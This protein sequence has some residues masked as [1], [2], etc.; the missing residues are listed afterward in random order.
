MLR[1]AL[2]LALALAG[3]AC[4]APSPAPATKPEAAPSAEPAPPAAPPAP[5]PATPAKARDPLCDAAA[6]PLEALRAHKSDAPVAY[7]GSPLQQWVA[8]SD[9]ATGR[10]DDAAISAVLVDT[11]PAGFAFVRARIEGSIAQWMR[12]RLKHAADDKEGRDAAW[13]AARCAWKVA[14]EPLAVELADAAPNLV[15]EIDAAFAAGEAALASGDPTAIDKALLPGH[16][17]VE[18]TWFRLAHRR[19]MSALAEAKQHGDP[20]ALA[21][22]RAAFEDLKDR[23]KDRNTP[24]IAVVETAL[25]AAPDKVDAD[26]IEREIAVA[27]VKRARKYC[28]EA[29]TPAAK[30][31]LG[32]AA[33][34]AT[35]AE[36]MA[37]TRVVLP[38]MFEKLKGQG[39]DEAAHLQA[40]QA[41]GDAVAEADADEA[42]RLSA[43]L[44]QWNC[45]YQRALAIRECTSSADEVSPAAP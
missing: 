23:L 2:V 43:D 18:K 39:F 35:A 45:A 30:G 27:L 42:R 24:G 26:K 33:A 13:A 20:V 44:V 11:T 9:A 8:A 28:D 40:W 1:A 29:L 31:P 3:T 25:A 14:L 16:E 34:M 5:P 12:D 15:E 7:N 19:L 10:H 32:S 38:D 4:N 41:Y 36:G 6:A 17:V 22:A 37:Y 21:R